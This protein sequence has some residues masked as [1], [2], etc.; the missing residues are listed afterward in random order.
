MRTL[1]IDR[2]ELLKNMA[3]KLDV[4]PSYLSS[5]E[6]GKRTPNKA[7]IDKIAVA[8]GLVGETYK[9]LLD[10]YHTS[11]DEISVSFA[12]A[13]DSQKSVGIAF[14]RKFNDLS[15]QQIESIKKI[16]NEVKC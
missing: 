16:L 1:R 14:A 6:N 2:G 10:A 11:I 13:T 7:L 4:V 5:I 9:D 15:E 8:Y 3:D 12:Q